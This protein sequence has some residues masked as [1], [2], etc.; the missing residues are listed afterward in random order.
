MMID[1]LAGRIILPRP[2]PR[3]I[4]GGHFVSI[5]EDG[6]VERATAKR[7]WVAGSFEAGMH[8]RA[9][10]IHELEFTG[11][12][13]KFLQGHNLWGP[14]DPR[15]LLWD[16][17]QRIEASG[18]LPC[19]LASLGLST[20]DAMACHTQL[21]RVDC[22]CMMLAD[23]LGDVLLALRSLRVA[24]R[25]RDRGRSGLPHPWQRGDGVSFGSKP[26]KSMTHRSITFYSKG[27][28]AI[29]HPLPGPMMADAETIEWTNKSLRCEV[30]LGRNYLKKRAL[31]E[32]HQWTEKSALGEFEQVF[33][34]M[35]M[36][37][38]DE[39]PAALADLPAHLQTSYGAWLGGMDLQSILSKRTFY[40]HRQAILEAV[41]VDIAIPRPTEPTAQLVPIKRII[42]LRPAG[43]PPFA[44]R[45][46][47]LLSQAA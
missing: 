9:P 17:L 31:R 29:V 42:E 39:Q 28:D 27:Q 43:R 19:S 4:D 36:N 6:T 20:P 18:A 21:S 13:A 12:P 32:L 46:E 30:R 24:G 23:S 33:E 10:G 41:S 45:I 15:E 3:P 2:L 35:D 44:D 8:I 5:D 37:G 16:A 40:R 26:G 1:Y 25:L 47:R 11:N 38:S 14:S 22:T 34:R 7:K